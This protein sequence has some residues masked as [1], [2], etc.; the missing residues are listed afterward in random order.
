MCLYY[1]GQ[2]LFKKTITAKSNIFIY[3]SSIVYMFTKITR[4]KNSIQ[5]KL[6]L[7]F[8]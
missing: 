7:L 8:I 5:I 6:F 2:S 3:V 4:L 1:L